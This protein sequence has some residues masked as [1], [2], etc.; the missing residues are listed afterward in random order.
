MEFLY[1]SHG[2]VKDFL[3]ESNLA[4]IL[5]WIIFQKKFLYSYMQVLITYLYNGLLFARTT[6]IKTWGEGTKE[7]PNIFDF[8]FKGHHPNTCMF[9]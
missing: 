7:A 8:V 1:R 2:Q 6:L 5:P 4:N 9:S 3:L